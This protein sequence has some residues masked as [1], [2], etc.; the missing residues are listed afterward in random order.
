M[1]RSGLAVRGQEPPCRPSTR[2]FVAAEQASRK[3]T[4]VWSFLRKRNDVEP[5]KVWSL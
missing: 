4:Y 2:S 3:M 1:Q 5:S